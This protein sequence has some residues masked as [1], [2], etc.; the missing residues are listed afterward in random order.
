[1]SELLEGEALDQRINAVVVRDRP[2][3]GLPVG[4]QIIKPYLEDCTTL[5]FAELLEREF[6]GCV[7]PWEGRSQ[8]SEE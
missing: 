4:V 5:A 1:V 6:G 3:A 7:P 8:C 2:A